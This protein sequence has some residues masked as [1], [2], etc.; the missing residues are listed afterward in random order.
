M[1]LS[2]NVAD[3]RSIRSESGS[4]IRVDN[5]HYDLT[6]EDLRVRSASASIFYR[7]L[8]LLP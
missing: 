2:A 3:H 1:R 7:I 8:T 4:K 6:D 5:L